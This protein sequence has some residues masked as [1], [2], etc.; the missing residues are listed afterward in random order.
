MTET[1]PV[2]ATP[3]APKPKTPEK[4]RTDW[5]PSK[6]NRETAK[7]GV[8]QNMFENATAQAVKTLGEKERDIL[9]TP[10]TKVDKEQQQQILKLGR[11]LVD[12]AR[13]HDPGA[14]TIDQ[15][16]LSQTLESIIKIKQARASQV[17]KQQQIT[18]L[19]GQKPD[20]SFTYEWGIVQQAGHHL[21]ER[22]AIGI[23][24]HQQLRELA[25]DGKP[26]FTAPRVQLAIQH[27][28]SGAEAMRTHGQNYL[29]AINQA[30]E[31]F[32]SRYP[33]TEA[34]SA[35][36]KQANRDK[37][38]QTAYRPTE[39][40]PTIDQSQALGL[41]DSL[42]N[43]A[44]LIRGT[45]IRRLEQALGVEYQKGADGQETKVIKKG[46]LAER[47]AVLNTGTKHWETQF[48][49]FFADCA[50]NP[51]L[52]E[53]LVR[54]GSMAV[55]H[56][57]LLRETT[58][59][60]KGVIAASRAEAA[61]NL[62]RSMAKQQ[63]ELGQIRRADRRWRTVTAITTAVLN[64]AARWLARATGQEDMH[65][66]IESIYRL[67]MPE[68]ARNRADQIQAQISTLQAELNQLTG[69]QQAT[70]NPS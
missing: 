53:Q 25:P 64:T 4:T 38:I 56:R 60:V 48:Q 41:V 24:I 43:S 15:E 49:D 47:L 7:D 68:E 61:A 18:E 69:R 28:A 16:T 9:T 12:F 63:N 66:L 11:A 42:V 27:L 5:R 26:N 1:N 45:D 10:E 19:R 37:Y 13:G 50:N 62:N 17:E 35:Q 57:N 55:L 54:V 70:A 44:H 14:D 30:A 40:P 59:K 21:Q 31:Q 52:A 23:N 3:E 39:R 33:N 2:P 46:S 8:I 34:E 32:T 67:G 36:L 6:E 51:Q 22:A 58:A 29:T 65:Q 20:R